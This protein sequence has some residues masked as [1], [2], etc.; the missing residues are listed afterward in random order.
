[1]RS[2]PL[3]R[4][5]TAGWPWS[6]SS[7]AFLA[8]AAVYVVVVLGGG[9][10]IGHTDSPHVGLSVL[11]T[12]IVALGFEPLTSRLEGVATRWV[13]GGRAAPYDVLSRFTE[14]LTGE[15]EPGSQAELPLRMARLLAEGTGA[16]WAQVWLVVDD[17]PEL[18]AAWPQ[19]SA[20]EPGADGRRG[21]DRAARRTSCS[22][23][24]CSACCG[25][26]NTPTQPL[27]PVEERL[28][29]GLAAQ[30]G[31]V[32]RGARLRADLA[33]RAADLATLAEELQTSRQRVVDTHDTERRRLERDIHDGAQQHLVALVVNLRLAQTLTLRSPDRARAVLA[34]QEDAV[35]T[36]ITTLVDL[37][38]RHLPEGPHRGR[39]RRGGARRREHS[40]TIP[41]AVLDH[42]PA[43]TAAELEA[44]LYFCCVEAVQ[45]AV[46][47]AAASR[48]EVEFATVGDRIELLV[49]DD[50]Q[51]LRRPDRPAA[52]RPRQHARPGRL[53]GWRPHRPHEPS[54]GTDVV[55]TVPTEGA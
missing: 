35:D 42:G 2:P 19:E 55:V 45:N 14:S 36:A 10:L 12:A 30:A 39:R 46:K 48:I 37:S 7:G 47:H 41:V 51:G 44:A 53:G 5:V 4:C 26:R 16:R 43:G 13:H 33:R 18:A 34:A 32:L 40:S 22:T 49:R 6:S 17:Q 24:R 23:V 29:A 1:M 54:R 3:G 9:L 15:I 27:A 20:S 11:A 38:A 31:L 25:C 8:V 52:G 50:G 21:R 28:F